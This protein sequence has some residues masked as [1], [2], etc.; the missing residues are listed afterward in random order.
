MIGLVPLAVG[1]TVLADPLIGLLLGRDYQGAG[2]LLAIGSL[3]DPAADPGVPLPD[4]PDRP[5]PRGGR[6]CGC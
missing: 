4:G 6:A 1:A 2:L 3:A 5:E